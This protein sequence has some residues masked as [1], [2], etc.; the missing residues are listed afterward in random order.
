MT[1]TI[2][3]RPPARIDLLRYNAERV[4]G[5]GR[6]SQG[7]FESMLRTLRQFPELF[8]VRFDGFRLASL[9]KAP[10]NIW[11]Y[12]HKD[13]NEISIVRVVHK[14]SDPAVLQRSLR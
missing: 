9:R 8:P 1:T 14:R 7:E 10:F 2:V 13:R 4:S 5:I 3:V 12:Y 6:W 11:Y